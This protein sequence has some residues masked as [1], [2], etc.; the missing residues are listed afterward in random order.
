M[1]MSLVQMGSGGGQGGDVV[2]VQ[3]LALII[4]LPLIVNSSRGASVT[5]ERGLGREII[6]SSGSKTLMI[7][8]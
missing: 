2:G 8:G 5:M 7:A 6:G 3:I 4:G 1:I